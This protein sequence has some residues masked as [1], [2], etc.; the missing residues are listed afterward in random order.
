MLSESGRVYWRLRSDVV[1]T[2]LQDG[3]VILD[4]RSKFFYSANPT[5]LAIVQMFENGATVAEILAASQKWGA[6]GDTPAVK[7]VIDLVLAEGLVEP[8]SPFAGIVPEVVV[9]TWVSP[10][11]SKHNEPL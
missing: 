1:T 4:L 3:G 9:T 10:V 2:V 7:Q 6:N 8:A 5:A 11:L